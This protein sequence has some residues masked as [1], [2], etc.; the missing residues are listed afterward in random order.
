[1]WN[2]FWQEILRVVWAG[3]VSSCDLMQH[4]ALPRYGVHRDLCDQFRVADDSSTGQSPPA[5]TRIKNASCPKLL[6]F[7]RSTRV[8]N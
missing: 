6:R 2:S 5:G 8:L 7:L 3:K 4:G 1:M